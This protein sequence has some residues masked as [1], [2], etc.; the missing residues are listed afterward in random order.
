MGTK[1]HCSH[2]GDIGQGHLCIKH[3]LEETYSAMTTE[4]L[5]RDS[6]EMKV[7]GPANIM[8]TVEWVASTEATME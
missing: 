3:H 8:V 4:R 6:I 5:L 7:G 2:H 1:T